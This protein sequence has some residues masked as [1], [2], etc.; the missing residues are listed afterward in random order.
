MKALYRKG[1]KSALKSKYDVIQLDIANKIIHGVYPTGTFLPSENQLCDLYN[2]S[3][4]TI[5]KALSAL[6]EQGFIQKIQGKGSI[7]LDLS[8]FVF[9]VSGITSFKELNQTQNMRAETRVLKLEDSIVPT[10]LFNFESATDIPATFIERLR[11]VNGEPVVIDRDYIVK[12]VIDEVPMN[13]ASDSLYSY[14]EDTLGLEISY[15]TKTITVETPSHQEQQLLDL[16]FHKDVVVVRSE[17]YL[18][19]T[20]L[21]QFTE[22]IHRA[23]KFSFADFARRKKIKKEH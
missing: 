7:V 21:F 10:Q 2:T 11:V 13:V 6:L 18:A 17:T 5:R 16:P 12:D 20:T 1:V 23:D 19:D 4:E 14:F 15:A 3:R 22:S 9:P 8:R